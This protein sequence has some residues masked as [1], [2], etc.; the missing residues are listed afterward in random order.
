[1]HIFA[2]T[3]GLRI[4]TQS[5]FSKNSKVI[6]GEVSM[7]DSQGKELGRGV[8]DAAGMFCFAAPAQAQEL[9]FSVNAGQG[10]RGSFLLPAAASRQAGDAAQGKRGGDAEG[11]SLSVVSAGL[12]ATGGESAHPAPGRGETALSPGVRDELL[13][14][15]R[16]E[17]QREISPLR[18]A[19]AEAAHDETPGL[20]DI[21]GGLGW[22]FGLAAAG[23]LYYK[24]KTRI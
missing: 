4:C 17:L 2:W 15:I 10:H 22:I 6:G 21:I 23:S 3:D 12:A 20:R 14:M 11:E 13:T 9:L 1:V 24:R 7:Q 16:Q 5:Y 8:S 19:L 18:Q